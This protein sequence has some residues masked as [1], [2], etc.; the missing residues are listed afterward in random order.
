MPGYRRGGQT[1]PDARRTSDAWQMHE[2]LARD[3]RE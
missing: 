3:V 2:A 1:L